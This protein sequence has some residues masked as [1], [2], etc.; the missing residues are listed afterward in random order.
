VAKGKY[1]AKAA[2]RLAQTDNEL[3]RQCLAERDELKNEL[4]AAREEINIEHTKRSAEVQK[5]AMELADEQVRLAQED[6]DEARAS[7]DQLG[8]F[9]VSWVT[10]HIKAMLRANPDAKCIPNDFEEFISEMVGGSKVGKY[11][12]EVMAPADK[13]WERRT[14]RRLTA[15]KMRD[16]REVRRQARKT[17]LMGV[18]MSRRVSKKD[19]GR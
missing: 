2:N 5:R 11:Y 1:A 3:L 8:E 7:R 12:S 18:N 9:A 14:V 13:Y 19:A 16:G 4:A 15:R 6:A 17:N 10:D